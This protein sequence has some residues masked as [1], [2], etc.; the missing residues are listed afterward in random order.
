VV[1]GEVGELRKVSDM[2]PKDRCPDGHAVAKHDEKCGA[3]D[4]RRG[5]DFGQP[6]HKSLQV[7]VQNRK[8][9]AIAEPNA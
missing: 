8:L 6:Y 3:R 1:Q 9:T 4:P 5:A 7:L 2:P